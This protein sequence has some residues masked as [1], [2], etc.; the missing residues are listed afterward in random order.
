MNAMK[1]RNLLE[2]IKTVINNFG[3]IVEGIINSILDNDYVEQVADERNSI[4][5]SCEHI[6]RKGDDCLAPGSQ[7]CCSLCGCSLYFK[8]R[9]LSSECPAGKWKAVMTE[10]EEEKLNSK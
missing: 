2:K 8:T 6:D 4:C 3:Q 7:P 10:E 9:S 1:K 5:S